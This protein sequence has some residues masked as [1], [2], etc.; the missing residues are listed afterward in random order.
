MVRIMVK[1]SSCVVPKEPA[2]NCGHRRMQTESR[3]ARYFYFPKEASYPI[4]FLMKCNR[5]PLINVVRSFWVFLNFMQAKLNTSGGW[6][7]P[8]GGPPIC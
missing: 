6:I 3:M 1:Q 8:V 2:A 5:F 4:F 7:Q